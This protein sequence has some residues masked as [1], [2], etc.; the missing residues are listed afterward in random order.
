M[1]EFKKKDLVIPYESEIP[2][3]I[4]KAHT[5]SNHYSVDQILR[6]FDRMKITWI[7]MKERVLK[8]LSKCSC[9]CSLVQRSG[10]KRL[11]SYRQIISQTP[12]ERFPNGYY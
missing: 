4:M 3:L 2:N 10:L 11:N 1:S 7:G 6:E 9:K 12:K 8:E 5:E